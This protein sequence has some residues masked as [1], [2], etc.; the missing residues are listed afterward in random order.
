MKLAISRASTTVRNLVEAIAV[1]VVAVSVLLHCTEQSRAVG[2]NYVDTEADPSFGA[3]ATPDSAFDYLNTATSSTNLQ[4]DLRVFATN[5]TIWEAAAN[6]AVPEVTQTLTGLTPSANYD[7]YVV[8]WSDVNDWTIQAGI[9][10]GTGTT[11]NRLGPTAA[12]PD[13]VAGT[14]G[15]AASWSTPPTGS[16]FFE[17]NRTMLLGKVG[18]AAAAGDGT[19]PVF[20]N[21]G[22][23]VVSG[24][25]AWLDGLAYVEAGTKVTLGASINR[26]TGHVTI[27]NGTDSPFSITSYSV[28]SAAGSLNSTQWTP[29]GTDSD[30]D[31]WN[32]VAPAVADDSTTTMT[33]TETATP[34][35][36]GSTLV[37]GTGELDL[38]NVWRQTPIQ[39]AVVTL[40]L[41]NGSVF[42]IVPDYT[43]TAVKPGD[44]NLDGAI[45]IDTDYATLIANLHA[46]PPVGT[47][48]AEA[49]LLGDM[50]G[51]VAIDYADF[52]AFVA[53]YDMEHGV[54]AFAAAVPEPGGMALAVCGSLVG[55]CWL[56]SRRRANKSAAGLNSSKLAA[57]DG[58]NARFWFNW[59]FGFMKSRNRVDQLVAAL[60]AVIGL[61]SWGAAAS[62]APVTGWAKD[63][64][65]NSGSPAVPLTGE[66]TDSPVLGDGV[67]DLSGDNAVIYASIPLTTLAIG[68]QITLSGTITMVGVQQRDQVFRWGL[69]KDDG[70]DPATGG[71]LGYIGESGNGSSSNLGNLW[72]RDPAGTSFATTTHMSITAGKAVSLGISKNTDPGPI[73]ADGTY[74]FTLTIGKYDNQNQTVIDASLIQS[75]G[76]F[77]QTW[78][79]ATEVNPT[80]VVT[81]FDRVSLLSASVS[82][83]EQMAFSGIDVSVAPIV[84]PK[85]QVV[86]YAGDTSVIRV[87]NGTGSAVDMKYY[88]IRSAGGALNVAG[89][90]GLDQQEGSDPVGTGWDEAG[91]S[92][93]NI[94]SEGNILATMTVADGSS[95]NLGRAFAMAGAQ[96]LTFSY[97]DADHQFLRGLVEY[98]PGVLG[99]V[100][101]DGIV[102]IFDINLISSNWNST[103]PTGDANGDKV[104]NI[105]DINLVSSHWNETVPG[106][107]TAVPEPATWVM[108]ALGA[109]FF[110]RWFGKKA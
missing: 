76:N 104:V 38:G 54:G 37:A 4:W 30:G 71:W 27:S 40:T 44:F 11:F 14:A 25:R 3:N 108:L 12:R 8:Y 92:S 17:G 81:S 43:G 94:L 41:D 89:W 62:A 61:C 49:F 5:G 82:D 75:G 78:A 109:V 100:N 34:T 9:A 67:T 56:L 65:N 2:L 85:L 70:V 87:L 19:L 107:T 29:I 99:D 32:V 50:T 98:V 58:V 88:E 10:S 101:F 97:G 45:D 46:T 18:T 74:D 86:Q 63:P 35:L 26:D 39:D 36:P 103:G 105:F 24:Q 16:L 93:A 51:D 96:D 69:F 48:A 80:R 59:E 95:L 106:S 77:N 15:I 13:L 60:L 52:N 57:A 55:G 53:A 31:M 83:A 7:V 110:V 1:A 6:E 102:N 28:S 22:S 72:S 64:L 33:E 47:T 73:P 90:N 84:A 20:I 66:L 68:E 23:S 79:Q 91:G 21:G 42:S